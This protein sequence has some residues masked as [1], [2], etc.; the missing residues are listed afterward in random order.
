[1]GKKSDLIYFIVLVFAGLCVG[2]I[3]NNDNTQDKILLGLFLLAETFFFVMI[4]RNPKWIT[5]PYD[6][7]IDNDELAFRMEAWDRWEN[8]LWARRFAFVLSVLSSFVIGEIIEE[9]F[10]SID[11]G[12]F[13][14]D[15]LMIVI[16]LVCILIIFFSI[17]WF[18]RKE[19]ELYDQ[20]FWTKSNIL[21]KIEQEALKGEILGSYE[22]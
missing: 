16:A 7:S 15:T 4:G 17:R 6:V 1:M 12:K 8:N 10:L 5:A 13:L 11:E 20:R 14:P 19:D 2:I 9:S 21:E 3:L 18:I 22:E